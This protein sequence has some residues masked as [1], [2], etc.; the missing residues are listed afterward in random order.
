MTKYDN[1]PRDRSLE[2]PAHDAQLMG[3]L[4]RERY[5]FPPEGIVTLT[6][7]QASPALR[8]TRANI[9]REFRRLAD[10]ARE[11]DQVVILLAGHGSQEPE[12][13]PDPINPEPD[14][15]NE[16]FLPADVSQWKATPGH[17]PNAI[18]DDDLGAWLCAITAKRAFVWAI[19]DCC[20]SGTMTRGTEVVRELPPEL[21][22]PQAELA[23][24]REQ[25]A[26]RQEKTRGGPAAEPA[27]FVALEPSEY[28]VAVY[29]CRP[30]EVT[31]ESLQPPESAHAT[32]HGLLTYSLVHVLTEAADAKAPPRTATWSGG[33]RSSTPPGPRARRR[34]LSRE[35]AKI[36]SSWEPTR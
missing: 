18:V 34:R 13:P 24:A 21:L 10:Q 31:P 5:Q 4:L 1:L 36:G 20:H 15:L 19:F 3:R 6:E 32:Y 12:N 2:G 28:L 26:K 33:F 17:V 16:I 7:D 35:K 27:P 9:E 25:A 8:P 30:T 22:V 23:R 11:G 14:G 29:A